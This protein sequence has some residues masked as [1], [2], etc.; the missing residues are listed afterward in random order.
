[1]KIRNHHRSAPGTGVYPTER[2]LYDVILL[3]ERQSHAT[4][5]SLPLNHQRRWFLNLCREVASAVYEP[6]ASTPSPP[7]SLSGGMI[8]L[9]HL[10][11]DSICPTMHPFTRAP[12]GGNRRD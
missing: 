12:F 2:V 5:N 6:V 4:S 10:P 1:M 8:A 3:S 9:N 7:H 11:S